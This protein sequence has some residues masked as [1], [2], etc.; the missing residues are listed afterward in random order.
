MIASTKIPVTSGSRSAHE[1]EVRITLYPV[2]ASWGPSHLH[3]RNPKLIPPP[4]QLQGT[5][6]PTSKLTQIDKQRSLL[7]HKHGMVSCN[8]L[9][10]PSFGFLDH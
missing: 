1:I 9:D 7:D 8:N 3:G 10:R 4:K 2:V 6:S 5:D